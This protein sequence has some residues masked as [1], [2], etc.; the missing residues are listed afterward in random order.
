MTKHFCDRCGVEVLPHS[1]VCGS[2]VFYRVTISQPE[3][4][5][6]CLGCLDAVRAFLYPISG[7]KDK[8][9]NHEASA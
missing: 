2:D 3:Q 8:R 6:L 9:W 1:R 5:V 7:P 4:Y